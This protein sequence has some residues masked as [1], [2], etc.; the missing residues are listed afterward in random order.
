LSARSGYSDDF[1]WSLHLQ[2]LSALTRFPTE[3]A[4]ASFAIS[5]RPPLGVMDWRALSGQSTEISPDAL[6]CGFMFHCDAACQWED[7]TDLRLH[8]GRT[9][10]GQIEVFAEGHGC[11][12]AA[13]DIFPDGEVEFQIHTWAV[14]RG[15]AINVPLNASD[16]VAYAKARVRALLPKYAFLPPHLR[17]TS[18][19]GGIVRG[20]EVL[21][22]PDGSVS[23]A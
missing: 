18:D 19:D 21:F 5:T 15:V 4:P 2:S 9:G 11:V 16:P 1:S 22:S 10:A 12:E 14:F 7:L 23:C 20:V 13:P 3:S 8:F 6:G 17:R